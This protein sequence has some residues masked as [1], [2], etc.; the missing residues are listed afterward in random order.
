MCIIEGGRGGG[1]NCIVS[2]EAKLHSICCP[3]A[4]Y[5][6]CQNMCYF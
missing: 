5:N 4:G 6:V 1:I 3:G 2:K